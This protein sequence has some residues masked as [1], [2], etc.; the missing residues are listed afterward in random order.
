[1]VISCD[2]TFSMMGLSPNQPN[3][4]IAMSRIHKRAADRILNGCLENGGLYIKLGQG[5]V[6]MNHILPQE[7]LDTLIVLHDKCLVRKGD[8]VTKLFM[9]DFG[10][11][12]NEVFKEFDPNPIAAASLAQVI[13]IL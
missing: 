12:P 5:L 7:Y 6:A 9:E 4:E 2:Y 11:G 8:E 1:M 3:Y 13:I 10:K